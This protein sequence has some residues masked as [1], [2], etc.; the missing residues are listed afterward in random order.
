MGD[1]CSYHHAGASSLRLVR[2]T[3]GV[4]F[5]R[6]D[7]EHILP[8]AC[9]NACSCYMLSHAVRVHAVLVCLRGHGSDVHAVG[10]V[11]YLASSFKS[12][13]SQLSSWHKPPTEYLEQVADTTSI[14]R[15]I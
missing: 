4:R 8:D 9:Q 14:L 10:H 15:G 11:E 13:R 5:Q 2:L 7:R 12:S 3:L 6:E 1:D